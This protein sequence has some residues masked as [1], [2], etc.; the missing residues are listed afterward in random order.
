M[1]PGFLA[2]PSCSPVPDAG[3]TVEL[4]FKEARLTGKVA[5]SRDP[6]HYNN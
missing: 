6:P 3:S 2:P 5:P 1:K 4:L